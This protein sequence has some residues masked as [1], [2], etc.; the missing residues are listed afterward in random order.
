MAAI[1]VGYVAGAYAIKKIYD[2]YSYTDNVVETEIMDIEM[3]DRSEKDGRPGRF[4]KTERMKRIL[5][6]IKNKDFKLKNTIIV[7]HPKEETELEK[8]LK[9]KFHMLEEC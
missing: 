1:Y 3:T 9:R 6:N 7:K 5:D 4:E 8:I 2:Y